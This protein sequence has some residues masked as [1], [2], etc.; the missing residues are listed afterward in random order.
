MDPIIGCFMLVI[1]LAV[2]ITVVSMVINANRIKKVESQ[3]AA[4]VPAADMEDSSA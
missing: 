3:V 2:L 1:F 4:E